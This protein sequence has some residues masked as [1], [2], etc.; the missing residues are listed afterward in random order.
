MKI[1]AV[2]VDDEPLARQRVR[3]LLTEE[4]DIDIV[5]DYEDGLQAVEQITRLKPDLLFLDVQMP[6]MDGFDVLRQLPAELLA[7]CDFHHSVRQ[8]CA[9]GF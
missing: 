8:A 7:G 3:L 5:A 2:I 4:A 6:E 1:R 9:A